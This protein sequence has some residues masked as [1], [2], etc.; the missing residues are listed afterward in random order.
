M[1]DKSK[2]VKLVTKI[3]V[4]WRERKNIHCAACGRK[5]TVWGKEDS[6]VHAC[7]ACHE[8]FYLDTMSQED[9]DFAALNAAILSMKKI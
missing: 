4:T 3:E 9:V 8:T 2:L 6:S 1:I 5:D 7:I